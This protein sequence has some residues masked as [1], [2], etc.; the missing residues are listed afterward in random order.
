M[1]AL[2]CSPL[3]V[4]QAIR[5]EF[6]RNRYIDDPKV[7]DV[8]LHKSR[9][10]YQEALNGWTQEPHILG[11]LLAPKE[12]P[13]RSFLEKFYESSRHIEVQVSTTS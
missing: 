1:Y 11:I 8:L 12:R 6:E 4:R 10:L 7:I 9:Q 2:T 5:A 3:T 13:E